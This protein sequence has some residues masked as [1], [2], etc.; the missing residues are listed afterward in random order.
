MKNIKTIGIVIGS[1]TLFILL[2]AKLDYDNTQAF[3]YIITFLSIAAGFNVTALSI[4]ANSQFSTRLY[5][6]EDKEDNSKTLLHRLV[7]MFKHSIG[8]FLVTIGLILLYFFINGDKEDATVLMTVKDISLTIPK[9]LKA[10]I[11]YGT[12]VSFIKFN[13]LLITFSKFVIKSAPKG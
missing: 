4:V 1:I 11:W 13:E 12:L 2:I 3:N 5:S 7:D 10:F 6:I 9:I 8:V